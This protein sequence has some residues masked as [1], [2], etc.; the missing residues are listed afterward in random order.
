MAHVVDINNSIETWNINRAHGIAEPGPVINFKPEA[1]HPGKRV[2]ERITRAAQ[3]A[4]HAIMGLAAPRP[5]PGYDEHYDPVTYTREW[6][7]RTDFFG[8]I[9]R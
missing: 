7:A 5:S 3:A 8:R 6:R 9:I 1:D 2:L 4:G